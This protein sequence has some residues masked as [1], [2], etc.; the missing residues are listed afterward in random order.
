[1]K[2][3]KKTIFVINFCQKLKSANHCIFWPILACLI[4]L[5]IDFD[6]KLES[7][8]FE[9]LVDHTKQNKDRITTL[10]QRIKTCSAILFGVLT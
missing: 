3:S 7:P 8:P 5:N 4:C 9:R 1:M 10:S 2:L 6:Q